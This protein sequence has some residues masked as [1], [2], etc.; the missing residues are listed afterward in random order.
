M[1]NKSLF[2]I[3]TLSLL[4]LSSC[5]KNTVDSYEDYLL[6]LDDTENGLVR[7]KEAGGITIKVKQL[8]SNYLAYQDLINEKSIKK[9]IVDSI[10]GSYEKSL[11]F[12]LTIGVD[13]DVKKGDIMFQGVRTYKEYKQ[14]LMELNFGIENNI[15]LSIGGNMYN[16]VLSHLENV[17]GL[18]DKRNITV[19]F[20]PATKEDKLFYLAEEIQF[21]YDDELFDTGINHFTFNRE[22]INN[23]PSFKFWN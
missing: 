6:W 11:T 15:S 1:V 20:V 22:D 7:D 12:L 10:I 9:S 5:G 2:Y 13:G 21:T 16:P 17:Y 3:G 23:N 8:P 18:T 14:Q 4:L 19:V